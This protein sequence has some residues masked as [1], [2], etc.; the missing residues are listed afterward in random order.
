MPLY[1]YQCQ[2]CGK[3]F[4]CFYSLSDADKTPECECGSKNVN[5]II[6]LGYGGFHGEYPIWLDDTTRGCLQ[7]P[8]EKPVETRTEFNRYLK[9]SGIIQKDSHPTN[10]TMI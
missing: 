7:K 4:E 10:R 6:K 9:E 3:E 2:D 8:G 5:K 1:D